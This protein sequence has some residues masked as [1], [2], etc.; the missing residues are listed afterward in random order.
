MSSTTPTPLKRTHTGTPA[1][2]KK[3]TLTDRSQVKSQAECSDQEDL[4]SPPDKK[5]RIDPAESTDLST[6]N[7]GDSDILKT[8]KTI[9]TTM[10]TA[11]HLNTME[12]NLKQEIKSLIEARDERIMVEVE[13]LK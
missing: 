7:M 5:Q 11:L 2:F 12:N 9:Q 1:G 4:Q 3:S 8:L 10:V 6:T 13:A